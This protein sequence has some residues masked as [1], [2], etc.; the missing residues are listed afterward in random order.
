M[1][2]WKLVPEYETYEVSNLGRLRRV[3]R[4]NKVGK[5]IE[6]YYLQGWKD[7]RGYIRTELTNDFGTKGLGMHQVVAMGFLNHKPCKYELVINHI[8]FKT[9]DNRLENLEVVTSRE[10]CNMK[11]LKST[12]KYTGVCWSGKMKKWRATI[13]YNEKQYNLGLFNDELLASEYYEKA[14]ISIKENKPIDVYRLAPKN[15]YW[16]QKRNKWRIIININGKKTNF[17]YFSLKEDAENKL[18]EIKQNYGIY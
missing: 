10:N 9:N 3:E 8:N 6:S 18:K 12:S 14:L 1:E 16:E 11:H 2:I 4:T 5:K 17:G 15:I 13:I 7:N